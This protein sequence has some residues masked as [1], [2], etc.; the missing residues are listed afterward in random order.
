M[1]SFNLIPFGFQVK[2]QQLVDVEHV[3]RGKKCLCVCPSC[4]TPLIAKQGKSKAWHFAHAS[5]QVFEQTEKHCEYSFYLSVR[6][7]ARQLMSNKQELL[8]PAYNELISE[9]SQELR[10]EFSQAC[11]ITT[12]HRVS[13]E[14]VQVE[15]TIC[16]VNLDII[17]KIGEFTLGI[18]FLHPGRETPSQLFNL[19]N[20]H[21]GIIA[22]DLEGL[23]SLF[24]CARESGRN[25]EQELIAFISNSTKNKKWLYHPR[26]EKL[27]H[28]AQQLL[29]EQIQTK[30]QEQ[31]ASNQKYDRKH[32]KSRRKQTPD[33]S[34]TQAQYFQ[35]N[36]NN[37]FSYHQLHHLPNSGPIQQRK[38]LFEC[39]MCHIQWQGIEPGLEVCPQCKEHLY[40]RRI[41][42]ID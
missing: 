4:K 13:L 33:L 6:L 16:G 24:I 41:K 27:R 10:Q 42:Y 12:S 29:K 20:D 17:G 11:E 1:L 18:F 22:F 26:Q 23:E 36:N 5:R 32:S 34:P 14:A 19:H 7:M 39:I 31:G 30:I 37:S 9:Y 21:I 35:N 15:Q 2:T 38:V 28:K 40:R 3:V 25:Y 8:L